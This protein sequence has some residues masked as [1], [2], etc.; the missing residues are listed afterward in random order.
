MIR[1]KERINLVSGIRDVRWRKSSRSQGMSNCVEV[2]AAN[3][4][5]GVRDSKDPQGHMVTIPRSCWA[6]F[7]STIQ[8]SLIEIL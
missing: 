1:N 3:M 6:N 4:L 8:G 2:T 5:I 7:I